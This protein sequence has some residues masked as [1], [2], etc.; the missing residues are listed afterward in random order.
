VVRHIEHLE[1]R[2]TR[3]MRDPIGFE[4]SVFARCSQPDVG[5]AGMFEVIPYAIQEM[6]DSGESEWP[7][8]GELRQR[9]D[10]H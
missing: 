4:E 9:M 10:R 2:S 5:W 3:A 1:R 8:A 7:M 6:P